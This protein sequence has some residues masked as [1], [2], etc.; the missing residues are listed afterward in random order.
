MLM[1][2]R[3]SFSLVSILAQYKLDHPINT[4]KKVIK[5]SQLDLITKIYKEMC[6]TY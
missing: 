3:M 6:F 4:Q 5:S 1:N 2:H